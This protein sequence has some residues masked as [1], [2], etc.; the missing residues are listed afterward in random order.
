M[1]FVWGSFT[2]FIGVLLLLI[3]TK[4]RFNNL[5]LLQR[6]G[7]IMIILGLFLPYVIGFMNQ[8]LY[9]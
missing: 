7:L 8:M 3:G 2:V 9:Q 6:L 4:K 1:A 5:T